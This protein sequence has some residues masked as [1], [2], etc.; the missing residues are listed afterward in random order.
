MLPA[1]RD[2][3]DNHDGAFD[4]GPRLPSRALNDGGSTHHEPRELALEI[5][6]GI[7]LTLRWA[8]RVTVTRDAEYEE[9][10][11]V[12]LDLSHQYADGKA[13]PFFRATYA[14][15]EIFEK[16]LVNGP[17][18]EKVMRAIEKAGLAR[19]AHIGQR[20]SKP[21]PKRTAKRRK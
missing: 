6:D 18:Q 16:T 2:P 13:V 3:C 21:K 15:I 8:A 19:G 12:R 7:L 17:V 11:V 20:V 9:D 1:H 10:G 5:D 14:S 4:T